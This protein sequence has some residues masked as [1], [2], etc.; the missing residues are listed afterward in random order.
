VVDKLAAFVS[1]DYILA[2]SCKI[3]FYIYLC[4]PSRV[5][6]TRRF[7]SLTVMYLPHWTDISMLMEKGMMDGAPVRLAVSRSMAG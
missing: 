2:I 7:T 4:F 5:D 3:P 6:R 1:A